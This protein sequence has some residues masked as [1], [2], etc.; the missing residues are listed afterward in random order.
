MEANVTP[1]FKKLTDTLEEMTKIYRQL[2][3]V[4]RKEK[5]ALLQVNLS[6]IEKC[7]SLKEEL[8]GKA[9]IAEMIREKHAFELG[10]V[11]GLESTRPRLL[12]LAVQMPY[13]QGEKLRQMHAA[14]DMVIKRIQ[15]LNKEN[16]QYAQLALR[17]LNGAMGN[18]KETLAGKNTYERKGHYKVGPEVSGNFVSKEA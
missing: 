13:E 7:R 12:E 2:L 3:D 16:E 1:V 10:S 14:L 4:V 17:T 11:V 6:E 18:I 9:R 5:E 15:E 8:I